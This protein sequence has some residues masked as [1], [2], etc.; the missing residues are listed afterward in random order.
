MKL[1]VRDVPHEVDF[2]KS[3]PQQP[4]LVHIHGWGGSKR[5][6]K[7]TVEHFQ[8]DLSTLTYDLRGFGQSQAPNLGTSFDLKTY[9][10]DLKI[11]LDQL[12]IEKIYLNSHS[13]GASIGLLFANLYPERVEKLI[14]TCSG[15][16][17]YNKV[18]FE[19]FYF[20][21]RIVVGFRPSWLVKVPLAPFLFQQRFVYKSLPEP[22]PTEFLE[23]YVLCNQEAAMG[24]LYSSVSKYA[25]D[26]LPK[27]FAQLKMPTLLLAGAHD[28]IIPEKLA[29]KALA[30]NPNMTFALMKQSGHFPMLEEPAI[31]YAH[32]RDF[33]KL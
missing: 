9:A 30:A 24:T 23:D 33:L 14:L 5:Y 6:W 16:Y 13:T 22:F 3:N 12:E 7:E 19:L 4:V 32:I 17:D 29:R 25:A 28:Q 11:I 26:E 31:Y 21:S 15:T 20:F 8:P 27:E 2:Q 1:L 10:E 18:A